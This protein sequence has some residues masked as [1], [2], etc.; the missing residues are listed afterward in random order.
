MEIPFPPISKSNSNSNS[1]EQT[2]TTTTRWF[3]VKPRTGKRSSRSQKAPDWTL[4]ELL[5]LVSEISAHLEADFI[6]LS[7]YQKWKLISD[8]CTALGVSR[9]LNQCRRQWER[10]LHEYKL[11]KDSGIDY[12][13][14]DRD[15][16]KDLGLPISFDRDLFLFVDDNLKGQDDPDTDSDPDFKLI[17]HSGIK[18]KRCPQPDENAKQEMLRDQMEQMKNEEQEQIGVKLREQAELIHAILK[19]DTSSECKE[20][21]QTEVR[22]RQATELIKVFGSLVESIEQLSNLVHKGK[23]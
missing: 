14:L 23:K 3:Q 11:I 1:M 6:T 4:P 9:S 18:R 21:E 16:L 22:R 10:L 8:N 5:V 15:K 19:G 2:S 13:S 12:W 17:R 7:T 20:Q